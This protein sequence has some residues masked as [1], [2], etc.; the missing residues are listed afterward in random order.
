[1]SLKG[2]VP[3]DQEIYDKINNFFSAYPLVRV[4]HGQALFGA[5]K[6]IPDIYWLRS[7]KIRL[8][9]IAEDGSDTTLQIFKSPAFFPMMFYLSHRKGDYFFEAI[10][11]VVAR[12]APAAEVVDYLKANPDV[13]FDLTKRFADAITGLLLRIEQLSSL[14]S[15]QRVA[16]LLLYLDKQFGAPHDQGRIIKLKLSHEDIAAWVGVARETVSR[17]IE[18]LTE[19]GLIISNHRQW[20]ILDS[21]ALEAKLKQAPNP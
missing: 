3:M 17:Q 16:S 13:L 5:E 10:E 20:I 2:D 7:G 18:K 6:E 8:Y 14:N 12:K 21:N 19:E 4:R 9:Q 15:L 11:E 1:M